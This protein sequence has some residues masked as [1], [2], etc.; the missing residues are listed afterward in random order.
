[1]VQKECGSATGRVAHS[2]RKNLLGGLPFRFW[3]GWATLLF[4]PP[5]GWPGFEL[6]PESLGRLELPFNLHLAGNPHSVSGRR[7]GNPGKNRNHCNSILVGKNYRAK[8]HTSANFPTG[9]ALQKNHSCT[10]FRHA[11]DLA[12]LVCDMLLKG[13]AGAAYER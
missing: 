4:S 11:C 2:I 6:I 8:R 12:A 10:K 3:K 13:S 5:V 9:T 7:R 1:M